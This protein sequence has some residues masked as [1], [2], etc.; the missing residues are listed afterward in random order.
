[1]LSVWNRFIDHKMS[2]LKG[3]INL[4]NPSFFTLQRR[5][6]AWYFFALI[7]FTVLAISGAN[8]CIIVNSFLQ[9]LQAGSLNSILQ[10]LV[11]EPSLISTFASFVYVAFSLNFCSKIVFAVYVTCLGFNC[12]LSFVEASPSRLWSFLPPRFLDTL[13]HRMAVQ[14][15]LPFL[16]LERFLCAY[17]FFTWILSLHLQRCLDTIRWHCAAVTIKQYQIFQCKSF[18]NWLHL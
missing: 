4:Y 6:C 12:P 3:S 15:H 16:L 9:H 2:L 5:I 7:Y 11:W 1:M 14:P 13:N 8:V 10:S 17:L 18:Q